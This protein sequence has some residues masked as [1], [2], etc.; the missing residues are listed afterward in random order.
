MWNEGP[1]ADVFT[2]NS[3]VGEQETMFNEVSNTYDLVVSPLWALVSSL[4]V[5]N[6]MAVFPVTQIG[7]EEW[8]ITWENIC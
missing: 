1:M 5:G 8:R 4:D 3:M 7:G 2:E 6:G